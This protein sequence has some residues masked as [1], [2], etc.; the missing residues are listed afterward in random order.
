MSALGWHIFL[1]NLLFDLNT[2]AII[3]S[4]TGPAVCYAT[5]KTV[6]SCTALNMT[7]ITKAD[8]L[9]VM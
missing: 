1:V 5:Q 6:E 3:F 4:P 2:L 8:E 7:L 9:D